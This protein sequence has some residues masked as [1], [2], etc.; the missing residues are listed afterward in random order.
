MDELRFTLA[1]SVGERI[2]WARE[3]KEITQ[4]ELGRLAGKSRAA[5]VQY[6]QDRIAAPVSVLSE[7]ARVLGVSPEFLAFG[8]SGLPGV[9][10]AEEEV[11]VVEEITGG[12]DG[13]ASSGGWGIPRNVFANYPGDRTAIKAI[14][15]TAEEP[16]FELLPGDRVFVDTAC[17]VERDG[18]YVI[19]TAF[20]HRVVRIKTGFT[21]ALKVVHGV[22]G[23]EESLDPAALTVI[24]KVVASMRHHF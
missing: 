5:I 14:V 1:Q 10:N 17:P 6:E 7:L 24:G 19:Q 18:L 20:G 3:R 15:V 2:K 13:T 4:K 22:D 23:S 21:T 9:S 11:M 16:A 8:R 12:R